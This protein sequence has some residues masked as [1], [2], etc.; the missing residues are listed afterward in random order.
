MKR[1]CLIIVSVLLFALPVFGEEIDNNYVDLIFSK[2]ASMEAAEKADAES[3]LS[4]F[5]GSD[6]GLE[7]LYLEALKQSDAMERN[8]ISEADLRRNIDALKTWSVADRKALVAAGASGDKSAVK[9]LNNKYSDS[10]A[11]DPTIPVVPVVVETPT[12]GS[13]LISKAIDVKPWLKDKR[14][15]DTINHWSNDHVSFLVERDII[16]GKNEFTFDPEA[17]ISKAEIVTL[18]TKL[19]IEDN[20]QIPVYTGDILD[21]T[22]GKWY[23]GHMQRGLV[24]NLIESNESGLL[25]PDHNSSREEVV[26][27]LILAINTLGLEIADELKVYKGGFVDYSSIT[28]SRKEAMTIAIN[29]GF[30]SGKGSGVLDPQSEIKRSEIA[31]VIKKL[32]LYIMEN[33]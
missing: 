16:S 1:F 18:V 17:S 5:I 30:I 20:N 19:I 25:E 21:I 28:E 8:N 3:L 11:V 14:F 22:S 9:A 29:L 10:V 4:S 6:V 24:L 7:V 15:P 2:F 23:D 33:M 31:V 27:I 13:G 12:I 26:E 32:Y